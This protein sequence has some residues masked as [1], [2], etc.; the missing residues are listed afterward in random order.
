MFVYLNY[1]SEQRRRL[2][3]EYCKQIP[4]LVYYIKALGEWDY[5][6]SFEVSTYEKYRALMMEMTTEFSDIVRN[7]IGMPISE[8]YKFTIKP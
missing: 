4:E 6:L 7:Y 5:E 2:F 3:V 1:S 8:I